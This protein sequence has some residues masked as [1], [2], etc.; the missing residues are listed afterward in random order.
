[1]DGERLIADFDW[2]RPNRRQDSFA[3]MMHSAEPLP[4]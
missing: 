1:M 3:I 4:L 2:S